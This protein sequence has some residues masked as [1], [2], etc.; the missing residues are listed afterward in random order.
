MRTASLLLAL[1]ALPIAIVDAQVAEA[2]DGSVIV[3]IELSGLERDRLSPDLRKEIDAL[4][5]QGLNRQRTADLAVRIETEQPTIA[6][7]VRA[8]PLPDNRARVIFL[9]ASIGD[10]DVESNVNARYTV[11]SV[12][13][14]GVPESRLSQGLRDELH[15]L[16]GKRLDPEK[17]E[18]L[19]K[20]IAGELSGYDV[21]RQTSKGD[22]AGQIRLVFEITEGESLQWIRFAPSRS[23]LLYHTDQAWSAAL[24]IP[25]GGQNTRVVL[26]LTFGNDD[27]LI[28]EYGG[29][30]FRIES[31]KLGTRRLGL[32]F[33]LAED[34]ETWQPSTLAALEADPSIPEAYRRRLRVE[35]SMTFAFNRHLRASGGVSISELES[36]SR[37]P[38]SQMASAFIF[39]AAFNRRWDEAAGARHDLEVGY[40]LRVGSTALDSD[41]DYTRHH[42]S[43]RYRFRVNNNN[44]I[45]SFAAGRVTGAAPMFERFSLGDT[46]TLRGWSKYDI[47]AAGGN[48]MISQSIEYRF[49]HAAVFFDA[50]SFWDQGQSVRYRTSAGFGLHGDQAF[51]TLGFPLNAGELRVAFMMGVRF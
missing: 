4:V 35:P 28:E 29:I 15:A 41:L 51:M 21:K 25:M 42:G 39:G 2:P 46:T 19:E 27:H 9:A 20:R 18:E 34:R 49:H 44:V 16:E 48:R 5:G 8:V 24:D 33:E 12:E 50:G 6:V 26:G 23:E 14:S 22:Q 7:A 13:I 30:G 10:Q 36:L 47:A 1:L 37:S 11:E 3:S 45:A 38:E 43:A 17:A 32:S 40:D 31:R